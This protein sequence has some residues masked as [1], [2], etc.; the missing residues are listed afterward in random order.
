MMNEHPILFSTEMVK[1]ILDGRKTQTRRVIKNID[2]FDPGCLWD[3]RRI[4]QPIGEVEFFTSRHEKIEPPDGRP[5]DL[6]WVRETWRPWAWW[7]GE[8]WV[9]QYRDG[10]RVEARTADMD[11]EDRQAEWEEKQWIK[12]SEELTK[13]GHTPGDDDLY[14]FQ[15]DPPLKWRPSIHMPRWVSR[16][17]LEV[18]GVR[19]ER[20]QDIS[21]N[22]AKAEG[23]TLDEV[24]SAIDTYPHKSAFNYLWDKINAKRGYSWD[25]NPWVWVVEFKRAG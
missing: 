8:R 5:G 22:D 20:V 6:L 25:S 1:A 17:N 4:G 3:R 11:H 14:H 2:K 24:G 23:V 9:F 19:V 15:G 21:E 12:I 10:C 13:A 7:E 18:T 16:I